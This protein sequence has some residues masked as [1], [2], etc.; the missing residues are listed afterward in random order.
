MFSGRV[1]AA[2][3]LTTVGAFASLAPASAQD[4]KFTVVFA[5]PPAPYLGAFYVADDKGFYKEAGLSMEYK[6]VAGDQNGMRALITGA[7]DVTIVG[8]PILYEA[9][10]NGGKVKGVGGGNQTLT[11]YFLVLG[12]AK[13][14]AL[15]DAVGK[16]LAIS[17]PGSMPQLLPEMMFKKENID[18]SGTRYL[19]IGGFS[20]R[21]QAVV[22]GKVDG[23]LVDTITAL[24]GEKTGD[25]KI[26]ADA[27][28]VIA[29]P[30]G[31]TFTITS[32]DALNDPARRKAL[33]AFVKASMRGARY[34]VDHPD[35]AAA[36]IQSRIKDTPIDLLRETVAKLNEEKVWG[37]NGGV[38]EKLHDFTMKTY[39]QF[40]LVS[41]EV[42]YKDAFDASL[43]DQARK[44]LGD[45][46][47]W[48]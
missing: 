43:V 4:T 25:V 26:V 41:K 48:Q 28:K 7:G 11:D 39:L 37:V 10:I 27:Q 21:L 35:E 33:Y 13:G 42:P 34:V 31:Y 3:L 15:K 22:A 6:T 36:S 5:T 40:K 14:A 19:P 47:G 23:S 38:G 16:T 45:K 18:S 1:L 24:R 30:L 32:Q 2:T 17:N 9:V 20:A 46:A 29:E 8:A 12:K 44:E